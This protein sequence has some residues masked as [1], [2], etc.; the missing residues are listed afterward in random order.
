MIRPHHTRWLAACLLG[1]LLSVWAGGLSFTVVVVFAIV[2]AA[3]AALIALD[4]PT[5]P[6]AEAEAEAEPDAGDDVVDGVADDA[7][8]D[9]SG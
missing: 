6:E 3:G 4:L 1:L 7:P 2:F 8:A 5:V 9:S